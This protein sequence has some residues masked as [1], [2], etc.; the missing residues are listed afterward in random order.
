MTTTKW[1]PCPPL[2]IISIRF[3]MR[4]G[5]ATTRPTGCY[6]CSATVGN[7]MLQMLDGHTYAYMFE[8]NNRAGGPG[9]VA[10]LLLLSRAR[11]HPAPQRL[12]L[13]NGLH[14]EQAAE[15]YS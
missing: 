15:K 11:R 8:T 13:P 12:V 10:D 1:Q 6:C 9:I 3:T 5:K 4:D 2:L 7:E 14:G